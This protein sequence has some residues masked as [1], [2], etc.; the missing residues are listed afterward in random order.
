MLQ[1]L[2][3]RDLIAAWL[4]SVVILVGALAGLAGVVWL[5]IRLV[6]AIAVNVHDLAW[7][8]VVLSLILGLMFAA[9]RNQQL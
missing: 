8:V 1:P 6:M 2:R 3:T 7:L 9:I 5:F 4:V